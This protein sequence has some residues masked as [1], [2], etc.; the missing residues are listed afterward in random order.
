M[1]LDDELVEAVDK[2]AKKLQ[3]TRSAFT[4][5]ALREAINKEILKS[6]EK[7]HRAGYEKKPVKDAEFS[8]WES[9][10]SWGY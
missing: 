8:I 2:V 1:T 6:L 7:K 4:H 5:F 9:E 3:T 10:Q